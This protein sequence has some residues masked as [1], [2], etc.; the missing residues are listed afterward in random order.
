MGSIPMATAKKI[1]IF[2][3]RLSQKK[4]NKHQHSHRWFWTMLEHELEGIKDLHALNPHPPIQKKKIQ[5]KHAH[6]RLEGEAPKKQVKLLIPIF[7]INF[8]QKNE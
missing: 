4:S 3:I 6:T 1:H 5:H 2:S 8:K 7:Y